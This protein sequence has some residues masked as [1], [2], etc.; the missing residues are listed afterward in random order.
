VAVFTG[1]KAILEDI[2]VTLEDVQVKDLGT[3]RRVI[4]EKEA[5]TIIEGGGS[6]EAIKG[7]SRPS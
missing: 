7:L 4:I 2:G 6:D 1:A 3:A 5:T